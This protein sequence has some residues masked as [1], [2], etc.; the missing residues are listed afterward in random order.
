MGIAS[1]KGQGMNVSAIDLSFDESIMWRDVS[2]DRKP[3]VPQLECEFTLFPRL[4][5]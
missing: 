5:A 4:P 2:G 1:Q 3:G